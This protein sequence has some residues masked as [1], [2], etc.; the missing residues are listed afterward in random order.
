MKS[1]QHFLLSFCS[2]IF[3]GIAAALVVFFMQ[4]WISERDLHPPI[5]MLIAF[6]IAH[7]TMR[8]FFRSFVRVQCAFGCGNK[9]YAIPGRSDRF[10]CEQCGKDM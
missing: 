9:A 6:I 2:S 5:I 1:S 10:R 8:W 4:D 7:I 3:A